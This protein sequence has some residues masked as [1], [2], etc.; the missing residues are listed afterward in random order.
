MASIEEMA[1]KGQEK[2][3]RKA[4]SMATSYNAS[5][6]R[7]AANYAAAG[8]GPTRTANYSSGINA[9]TYRAPDPNKWATNWAAKMRE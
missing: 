5:K 1:R 9:A 2:L 4:S 3:S 8:F 6:Q 7:A